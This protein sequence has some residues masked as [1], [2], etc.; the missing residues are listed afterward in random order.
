[1]SGPSGSPGLP[2]QLPFCTPSTLGIWLK[3]PHV[4]KME[5]MPL[6]NDQ[7]PPAPPPTAHPPVWSLV[8][9]TF[10]GPSLA[11]WISSRVLWLSAPR[12]QDAE[13]KG[14]FIFRKADVRVHHKEENQ[15][16]CGRCVWFGAGECFRCQG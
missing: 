11:S 1:M 13:Q 7:P 2:S 4:S 12:C 10:Q 8:S 3:G 14:A 6:Q 16:S 9:A 5:Q 15:P